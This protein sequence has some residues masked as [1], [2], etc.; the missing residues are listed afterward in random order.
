MQWSLIGAA[1]ALGSFIVLQPGVNARMGDA[2]GSP[3]YGA[4]IS[5][6]GGL[7]A[8]SIMAL[9]IR[10]ALP[11]AQQVGSAPWWAWTGGV[12]GA[13]LVFVSLLLVPKL[14]TVLMFTGL[15]CGQ[16]VGSLI[17]DHFGLMG[18]GVREA[19]LPRIAGILLL[20]AG[21]LLIQKGSKP[22]APVPVDTPENIA[23]TSPSTPTG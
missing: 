23:E 7:L 21:L 14:G 4:V 12:F 18:L 20:I 15:I 19:N 5:F 6:A 3:I 2:M 8:V 13:V 17:I 10:P 11:T 9:V 1:V 22:L 16:M